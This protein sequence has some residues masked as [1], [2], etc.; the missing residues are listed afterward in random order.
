MILA[1]QIYLS[2]NQQYNTVA[3]QPAIT[4]FLLYGKAFRIVVCALQTNPVSL[5]MG[6][7]KGFSF[8]LAN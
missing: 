4:I 7:R 3:A 2:K 1:Y 5:N 8:N 6:K